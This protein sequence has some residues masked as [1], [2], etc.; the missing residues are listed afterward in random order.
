MIVAVVMAVAHA[1]AVQVAVAIIHA[2]RVVMPHASSVYW[3]IV[4][5]LRE[6][7]AGKQLFLMV[8]VS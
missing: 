4:P 5:A 1:G 7:D 2:L 8:E 6:H 3:L